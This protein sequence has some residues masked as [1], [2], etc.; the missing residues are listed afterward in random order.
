MQS[1]AQERKFSHTSLSAFRRCR[2][3]FAWSYIDDYAPLPGMGLIRGSVGHHALATWYVTQDKSKTMLAASKKL[4]EYEALL[5]RVLD[6]EWDLISVVLERYLDWAEEN[7][8]FTVEA[9]EQR[10]DLVIG[11]HVVMGFID[12]IAVRTDGSVWLLEHKFQ[13]QARTRHLQMDAQSSVYLWAARKLGYNPRGILYNIIRMAEG[14]V[15]AREP[16]V[17]LPVYRNNEGLE[18]MERELVPQMDEMR[19]ALAGQLPIY[20]NP[21]KDCSWDCGFYDACLGL[22]DNGAAQSILLKYPIRVHEEINKEVD[23]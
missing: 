4:A 1:N 15:A 22:Q 6:T 14:G 16:V 3:K 21:T 17:R 20:R 7:D 5:D 10:F 9:A 12:G 2:Q 19:L 8:N 13:K 18:Y 11:G 23:E